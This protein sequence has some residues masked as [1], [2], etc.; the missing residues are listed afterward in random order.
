MKGTVRCVL[1]A[2]ICFL[3]GSAEIWAQATAEI[4]GI[5]SD[6]S[7]AVLPGVVIQATQTA[8]GAARSVLS[9]EDGS[10]ALTNL[11]IGPYM[12]EA[13][14][15]GFSVYVQTGIVLQVNS[16]PQVNVV[17]RVGEVS[18]TVDVKADAAMVETAATGV[19]TV[20]D[21]ARVQDLPLN[22]RQATQ[23]I[24]L[25][26][27][28]T[29]GAAGLVSA[30]N[31]PTM[32]S[33]SVA[34]GTGEGVV[35]LLDGANHNDAQNNLGFP[36]PFP[37]ALQEFKL[38]TSA[39]PAQY[40][41][42]SNAVVTAITKSG[43]NEFHGDLFEFVRNGAFNARNFFAAKRD[44]LK[45]NQYGGVIGGPIKKDKLFFFGGYQR[46]SNRSDPP[47]TLAYV[48]TPAMLAGDFTTIASPA[49]N[50]GRQITLAASQGFVNNR[51]SPSSFD[52]V[53]MNIAKILPTTAD[54]CGRVTY[55]LK[56][57]NDEHIFVG[58]MD[59]QKTATNSFFGRILVANFHKIS[60]YDG[61]NPL[62]INSPASH[63]RDST[64]VFGNT[65]SFGP[66]AVNSFR[67]AVTRSSVV[68]PDDVFNSWGDFGVSNFTPVGG[69]M[70]GLSVTG[71][72]FGITGN[73]N[74]NPTGPNT[75]LADDLSLIKGKHQIMLG[76]SYLHTIFNQIANY[77]AHG[78]AS[79]NG[80]VTGLSLA[81]F[82]LGNASAWNQANLYVQ[83]TRQNYIG[84][85]AQDSWKPLS[86]LTFNY[87]V[88][89]EPSIQP[90]DAQNRFD[91][92]DPDLFDQNVHSKVFLKA[93][94]GLIFN[95]DS[96]WDIGNATRNSKYARF[97]PRA[98]FAWDVF[99]D[100]R[101]A[102]RGAY[103]MF[104]DVR[105][106]GA[107]IVFTNDTPYGDNIT[108]AN[109]KISNPWAGYPDGNPFPVLVNKDTAFP[110][111]SLYGTHPMHDATTY[112]NQWN[113]NIE[114]QFGANW[115]VAANYVGNNGIH[116]P[117]PVQLN[118]AVFLGLGPCTINGVTYS[119]CSTTANT[120][121]RRVLY[122]KNPAEG[123]Y[124]SGVARLE[125]NATQNYNGLL[126]KVQR[127]LSGGV[128]ILSN[129]TWSHCISYP[130][131]FT[132]T[133]GIDADRRRA[134]RSNCGTGDTRQLFNLS[135]VL[136]APR[137]TA[138]GILQKIASNWQIS[139]IMQARSS[140]YFSVT[141]G[142]DNA[143]TGQPNQTPN[144]VGNPYPANQTVGGWL[145]RTA[146]QTPA[147]GAVGNL[148][149][150]NLK[151]PSYFQFDLALSR[152]F[153]IK[154]AKTIQ[155]RAETFNI[156]NHANF[157]N[158]VS[159][160]NSGAFGQIQ[161]AND[162]RILQFALK[163]VF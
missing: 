136:Q 99:G 71:N 68:N 115:L 54:P 162:P 159:T 64:L 5:V 138:T 33:I 13:S 62:T 102:V 112:M 55:G 97:L 155:L 122:L 103:G 154:E 100:G 32:I 74:I 52:P 29:P 150:N 90:Y 107:W 85:Y 153:T 146:F 47:T 84:A 12:V 23:L 98:G 25:A 70:L 48:P 113:L 42:H 104:G 7:G 109:V 59:Y 124:Y 126:L 65:Y 19:G 56:N 72:G 78:S 133:T 22:G 161:K 94:A 125:N 130:W 147:I 21:N 39:L 119:T 135:A 129:Y 151:G 11:P 123:Q 157:A 88:R 120:N 69:K 108:L 134:F 82:M 41:Y 76:G 106:L 77:G 28:A 10:Y 16:K 24:F 60:S 121:Q 96:N 93:P 101:M 63:F 110:L 44:S 116:M 160:L 143:L 6:Q 2:L 34:G 35:Y 145:D 140:Q 75:N 144:L 137:F 81:D 8:T 18:E 1:F 49:C 9:G 118:P 20:I 117:V 66:A 67:A 142:V 86:R 149:L 50:G 51:I 139:P 92:F 163:Y 61:T 43:T 46:T 3:I 105:P 31:Y 40:G 83:Y 89:W 111:Y 132:L 80:S 79:F 141:L 148:G 38:E 114:R 73:L 58:K 95:G 27:M 53:A 17:L 57:N 14:L 45:R 91:V 127:R 15:P 156:L 131:D 4:S 30:R 37:D 128:S 26:G 158:P 36:L 152:T 87:G